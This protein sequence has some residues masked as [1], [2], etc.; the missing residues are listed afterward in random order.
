MYNK[1]KRAQA[2]YI[3]SFR[4]QSNRLSLQYF[5]ENTNT[6]VWKKEKNQMKY[7]SRFDKIKKKPQS[8]QYYLC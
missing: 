1:I 2:E 6:I 7:I 4:Q 3:Q 8:S 5:N